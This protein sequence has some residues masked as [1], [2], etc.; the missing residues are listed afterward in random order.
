MRLMPLVLKTKTSPAI[1]IREVIGH[2][3]HKDLVTG[4]D[5]A[6][7]NCFALL[8]APP[9]LN[10]KI[11]IESVA[12]RKHSIGILLTDYGRKGEEI[13]VGRF[14]QLDDDVSLFCGYV[15]VMTPE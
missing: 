9:R 11:A 6:A 8:I 4:L 14:F 13:E 12:R 15:D 5:E 2:L 1:R 7:R 10:P 3:V